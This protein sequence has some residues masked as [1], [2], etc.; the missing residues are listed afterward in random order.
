MSD[1]NR[2]VLRSHM[3]AQ[4]TQGMMDS[5]DQLPPKPMEVDQQAPNGSQALNPSQAL[6][7]EDRRLTSG[8]TA[9]R[10]PIASTP[11]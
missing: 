3:W 5:I 4:D 7:W 11:C 9:G 1:A 10:I 2:R 6:E 8:V